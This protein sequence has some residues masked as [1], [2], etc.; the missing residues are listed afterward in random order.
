M[1]TSG[2]CWKL[3]SESDEDGCFFLIKYEIV[4]VVVLPCCFGFTQELA[5]VFGAVASFV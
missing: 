5:L 1:R 2:L 4:Y 3:E